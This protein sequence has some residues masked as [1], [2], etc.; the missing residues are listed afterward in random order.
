MLPRKDRGPVAIRRARSRYISRFQPGNDLLTMPG[1]LARL[2]E[3][4]RMEDEADDRPQRDELE[5]DVRPAE[6]QCRDEDH[7]IRIAPRG[8]QAELAVDRP[9]HVDVHA[10]EALDEQTL[11][12][13]LGDVSGDDRP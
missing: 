12:K 7:H 13:A 1:L 5:P 2:G 11:D 6:E 9:P 3:A 8:D 10:A 4:H